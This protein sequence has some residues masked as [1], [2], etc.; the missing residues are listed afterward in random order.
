MTEE[1]HDEHRA[2]QLA[3]NRFVILIASSI[4]I[5]LLLVSVALALYAWSGAAQVDLSR[6]G[7][8]NI[9]NQISGA[10]EPTAFPSSGLIDK[11]VLDS[12]EKLYDTTATQVTSVNAFEGGALSD[13]A[14]RINEDPAATANQ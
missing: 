3:K 4:A 5:A 7:Y 2:Y 6:P 12:F 13:E 11:D 1:Q 8:D 9:R 10:G 14:L